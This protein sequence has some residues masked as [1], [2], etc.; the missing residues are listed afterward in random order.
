MVIETFKPEARQQVYARYKAKG[1]MLPAGLVYL[2]SWVTD[3]G[4]KCFQLMETE[5]AGLFDQWIEIWSDLVNFEIVPV[6]DSPTKTA[7]GCCT[8]TR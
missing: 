5:N 3:D 4:S 2:D 8:S 6:H 1:R 7:Q